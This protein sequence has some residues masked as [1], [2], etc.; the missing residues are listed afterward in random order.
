[1]QIWISSRKGGGD[2]NRPGFSL[3]LVTVRHVGTFLEDP[4]DVPT[5]VVNYVAGQVGVGDPSCVKGYLNRR[6]TRFEHQAQ[7]ADIYGYVLYASAEAEL[8]EWLDRQA[9]TTGDQPRPLFYAA[10]GWLRAK[11]ALLPGVSTLRDEVASVRRKTETRLYAAL[12]QAIT[13]EQ[14]LELVGLLRISGSGRW[15]QLELWRKAGKNVTGRGMVKALNR[16][17]EITALNLGDVDVTG[18]PK[19][20]LI[21]LAK[22]G[23]NGTATKIERLPY[24]KKVATLLATMRWLEMSATDDALELFDAFMSNELIGRANKAVEK[25]TVKRAPLVAP[26]LPAYC[27]RW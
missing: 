12:T 10:V 14:A 11:K 2:H 5:K 3:Q 21:A 18:V 19:R 25:A 16:V 22:E 23:R 4:L 20:R 27:S 26:V 7:I 15:S 17:S 24:E 1:M 9:W 8:I 6:T 13:G